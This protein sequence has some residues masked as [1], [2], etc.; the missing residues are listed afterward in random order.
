M[1]RPYWQEPPRAAGVA[2]PQSG[3]PVPVL[4]VV[5]GDTIKIRYGGA[6]ESVRLLRINTPERG[7]PGYDEAT[8]ALRE[9]V[10][11]RRV[12]IEFEHPGTEKRDRYDRLL[13]Y[14]LVDDLNVNV[15]LVRGGWTRF[16]TRYGK[17]RLAGAFAAAE[18]E[19]RRTTTGLWTP[20]GWNV[21][22]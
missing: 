12:T 3:T 16:W 8:G 9:L 15:E 13:A 22:D 14:V 6:V 18:D 4:R 10:D 17:G 2:I 7:R 11:G 5:D 20:N 21:N 19:A 1:M